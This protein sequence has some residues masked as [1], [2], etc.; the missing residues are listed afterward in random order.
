LV[1]PVEVLVELVG[2]VGVLLVG[3]LGYAWLAGVQFE[4]VMADAIH[5]KLLFNYNVKV[6]PEK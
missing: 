2:S 6:G 4:E 5:L 1:V 3:L